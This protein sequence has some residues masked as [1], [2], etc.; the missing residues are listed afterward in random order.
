MHIESFLHSGQKQDKLHC[1]ITCSVYTVS[2]SSRS[3]GMSD[4]VCTETQSANSV[5]KEV[6]QITVF[7]KESR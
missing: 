2:S 6:L 3:H 1:A 5:S 4:E 7:V